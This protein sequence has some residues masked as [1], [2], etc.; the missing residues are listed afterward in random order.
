MVDRAT[1]RI[2]L[3]GQESSAEL[4]G[5]GNEPCASL[6][7]T[8]CITHLDFSFYRHNHASYCFLLSH[9]VWT[10]KTDF[11]LL[12]DLTIKNNLTLPQTGTWCQPSTCFALVT[13]YFNYLKSEKKM[14]ACHLQTDCKYIH[15]QINK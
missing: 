9:A 6:P 12:G 8:F 1:E 7:L 11:S 4:D 13:N 10:R 2:D 15:K 14:N 3:L 5:A